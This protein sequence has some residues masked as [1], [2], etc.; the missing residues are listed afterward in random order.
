MG[1]LKTRFGIMMF[2]QYAIWGSWTTALGA[3]LDKLGFS[4]SEISA[5]YGCLW[6]GCIIAPFIGLHIFSH[7]IG[8]PECIMV[9]SFMH[10]ITLEAGLTPTRVGWLSRYL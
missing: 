5:I 2:L 1:D 8:G 9:F 10:S 6:L 7:V 4:G 3:H